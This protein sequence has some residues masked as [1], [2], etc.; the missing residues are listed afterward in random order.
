MTLDLDELER[1]EREATAG[2]WQPDNE[3][4]NVLRDVEGYSLLTTDRP[5]YGTQS[6]FGAFTQD[7]DAAFIAALRNAA[8][9][10]IARARRADELEAELQ[11]VK[12]SLTATN[13]PENPDSSAD[14]WCEHC[15][16]TGSLDC[17]CG[18]D[19]CVCQNN[20]EYP[21][22]HCR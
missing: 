20:G 16:N 4:R 2:P 21:C 22:P 12:D 14:Q 5:S 9:A 15:H 10:L 1:L 6:E 19:L 11:A 3:H 18:G 8:P 7:E 13:S 17:H